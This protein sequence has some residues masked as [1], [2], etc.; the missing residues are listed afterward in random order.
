MSPSQRG[1]GAV[2]VETPEVK[3][4]S[5]TRQ[6]IFFGTSAATLVGAALKV[7]VVRKL[8]SSVVPHRD[9]RWDASATVPGG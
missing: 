4:P 7:S 3:G 6:K 8:P 5:S 9:A 2:G 1:T